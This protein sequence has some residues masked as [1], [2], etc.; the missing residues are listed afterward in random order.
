MT[1]KNM[2]YEIV[3]WQGDPKAARSRWFSIADQCREIV[4][5]I[6]QQWECYHVERGNDVKVQEFAESLRKFRRK[7]LDKKPKLDVQCMPSELAKVIRAKLTRRF[8]T[9][10]SRVRELLLNITQQRMTGKD[11]EGK[12]NIWVAVLLNRQGRPNAT[13]DQPIPFDRQNC[14][15]FSIIEGKYTNYRLDIKLTRLPS[16]KKASPSL[17]DSVQLKARGSGQVIMGRVVSGEYKFCGSSIVYHKG[18]RKWFALIAY[19]DNPAELAVES[20]VDPKKVATLHPP[21]NAPWALWIGSR[22]HWFGGRG[23]YV[24]SARRRLLTQRWS[25]QAN[26]RHAGS[27]N[28][29]HGRDRAMAGVE[30]LSDRWK[31]FCKTA[32]HTLT[33]QVVDYCVQRGIG[34]LIYLQ[35]VASQRD[36]RFLAN[37]GKVH[38]RHDSTGWDWAQVATLLAYKCQ[39]VGIHLEVRK[40]DGTSKKPKDG[41]PVRPVSPANRNKSKRRRKREV[42]VV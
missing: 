4:N 18:K 33:R 37:A 24:A 12:W 38:G 7:E 16:D 14:R 35:P 11:V 9:T 10:H 2:R 13:H 3:G 26:Y 21:R 8:P 17:E 32:N 34:H 19:N 31:D 23:E 1:V 22:W 40:C 27:A 20:S 30:K 29:G 15:P 6:W 36:T 39:E 41:G 25:R 28:K 42:A 5:V